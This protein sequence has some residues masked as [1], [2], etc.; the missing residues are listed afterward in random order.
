MKM[1]LLLPLA[2]P[3]LNPIAFNGVNERSGILR[4]ENQP[5]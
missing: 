3:T 4:A 2:A 5:R 1:E